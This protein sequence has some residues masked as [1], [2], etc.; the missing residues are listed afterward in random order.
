[1]RV[2]VVHG[3]MDPVGTSG[4]L[5][6]VPYLKAAGFEVC[7]PDYPLITAVEARVVNPIIEAC[8]RAYIQPGDLYVGHSNGCAIGY[9]LL[10]GGV[11][12]GGVAFINAALERYAPPP[13]GVWMDVYFNHGD[14]ATLAAQVGRDLGL[15]SPVWGDMGHAGFQGLYAG[16]TSIDCGTPADLTLP[17]VSGHSDIFT[18]AKLRAWGPFI[19]KRILAHCQ[20]R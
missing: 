5:G 8:L 16:V 11:P 1:M 10:T 7:V 2:H 13:K 15:L 18:P 4:L 6:L 3:I 17:T 20:G 14:D 9:Q 19:T 12:L